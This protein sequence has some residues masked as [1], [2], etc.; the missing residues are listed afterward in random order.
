MN[1]WPVTGS[2]NGN[3]HIEYFYSCERSIVDDIN[4]H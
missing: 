4:Q 2:T 1:L 3:E